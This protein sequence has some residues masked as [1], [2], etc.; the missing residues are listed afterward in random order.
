MA[1]EAASVVMPAGFGRG[2][3]TNN[4][5]I[6]HTVLSQALPMPD[7]IC[8]WGPD[9]ELDSWTRP[10]LSAAATAAEMAGFNVLWYYWRRQQTCRDVADRLFPTLADGAIILAPRQEHLALIPLLIEREIP[11]VIAYARH[12][13]PHVPWVVCD[14]VGGMLQATR[15]IIGLGHRRIGLIGGPSSVVDLQERKQGFLAAMAEAGLSVDPSLMCEAG[16]RRGPEDVKPLAVHLLRSPERPSAVVCATD[17]MALGV[18]QAA[19]DLGLHVPKDVAVV[20]FDDTEEAVQVSP[21]LT[22]VRQPIKEIASRAMYLAACAVVGQEP[23]TATWHMV[24][25]VPLIV[26]ESCGASEEIAAPSGG[27]LSIAQQQRMRQLQAENDELHGLLYVASHDLRS[28]LV[29]IK[30][31]ARRLDQKTRQVLDE[32]GR[33]SLERIQRSAESMDELIEGLLSL[34]RS[35]NQPLNLQRVSVQRVVVN[36]LEDLAEPIA[37]KG[38]HVTAAAG[39]PVVTADEIGLRQVFMNLITNALKYVGQQERPQIHVGF[40]SRGAEHEFFVQ[41]NGEGIPEEMQE[42]IFQPFQRGPDTAAA[43]GTGI[44]LSIVKGII[45]RHGGRLWVESK[46][47]EGATFRFTLPIRS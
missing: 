47:G 13:D 42:R 36:V 43:E 12:T 1:P 25:P 8:Q 20:G 40:G 29:T 3:R 45:V 27:S 11:C 2:R 28:P 21:K 9:E 5:A 4:I 10:V 46:P 34:S 23:E 15:H 19:W 6:I 7:R 31:F 41:D 22:T 26:R 17:D 30:G 33:D 38:A 24:C 32:Q 35:Y 16:H 14:N 39:L 44:G 37:A 18:V